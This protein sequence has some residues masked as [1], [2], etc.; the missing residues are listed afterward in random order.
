MML[1]NKIIF[2]IS[3]SLL[4]NVKYYLKTIAAEKGSAIPNQ[5]SNESFAFCAARKILSAGIDIIQTKHN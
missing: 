3:Y 4:L 1:K 2:F 5:K